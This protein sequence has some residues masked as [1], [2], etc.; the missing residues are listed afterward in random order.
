MPLDMDHLRPHPVNQVRQCVAQPRRHADPHRGVNQQWRGAQ[1][2]DNDPS[3]PLGP[4]APVVGR[5]DH[6]D[7]SATT[8]QPSGE[9]VSEVGGA[10]DVRRVGVRGDQDPAAR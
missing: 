5:A 6:V 3:R 9:T 7:L 2:V 1:P 4:W 10:V 8:D